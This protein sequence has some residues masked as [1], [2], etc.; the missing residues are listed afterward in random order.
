MTYEI[1]N[2]DLVRRRAAGQPV[3]AIA[4]E[5]GVSSQVISYRLRKAGV[6]STGR[7]N[8][9]S[10]KRV[11]AV[12]DNFGTLEDLRRYLE[13]RRADMVSKMGDSPSA[14]TLDHLGRL[15]DYINVLQ[16]ITE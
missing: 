16:E 7:K 13:R 11:R 6:T 1:D 12:R 4:N 10:P 2:A 14:K 8:S 5:L 3:T 9:I 15:T